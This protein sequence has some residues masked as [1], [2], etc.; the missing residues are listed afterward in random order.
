VTL[1]RTELRAVVW[2]ALSPHGT[3]PVGGDHS[4][5][6]TDAVADWIEDGQ[7]PIGSDDATQGR[8]A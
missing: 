1:D 3:I 2:R 6:I 4:Q 8:L 7:H 5:E